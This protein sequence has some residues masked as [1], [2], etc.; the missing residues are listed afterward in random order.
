MSKRKGSITDHIDS[1]GSDDDD[2]DN[3]SAILKQTKRLKISKTAGELR[4]CN[5][6]VTMVD[7]PGISIKI[8]KL[9]NEIML[10]FNDNSDDDDDDDD[11]DDDDKDK[12]SNKNNTSRNNNNINNNDIINNDNSNDGSKME[13][14]DDN[15][16][17]IFP[18]YFKIEV[19]R[20]YPHKAPKVYCLDNSFHGVCD[21]ILEN[22]LINHPTLSN[23][24]WSGIFG[25][26]NVVE[27][28][29][30][31]RNTFNGITESSESQSM[32]I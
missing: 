18:K 23:N 15:N 25:L 22:G 24:N 28:L 27:I 20:H 13:E 16:N 4:L 21:T 1:D 2:T 31:I 32:D 17:K 19:C 8:G 3:I 30:S 11:N 5:E 26:S 6:L 12:K 14:D 10:K 29:Q 9:A 7:T